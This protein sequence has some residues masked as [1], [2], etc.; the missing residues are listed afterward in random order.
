MQLKKRQIAFL[1]FLIVATAFILLNR[2]SRSAA[3]FRTAEGSI[4]PEDVGGLFVDIITHADQ[5]LFLT[6]AGKY[7]VLIQL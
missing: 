7:I 3:M 5:K 6:L 1:L 2:N 4:T